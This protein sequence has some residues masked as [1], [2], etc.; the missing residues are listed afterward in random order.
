[1]ARTSKKGGRRRRL[2]PG[3]EDAAEVGSLGDLRAGEA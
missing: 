3:P 1:M 2:S